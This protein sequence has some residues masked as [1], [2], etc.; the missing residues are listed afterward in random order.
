[1]L[2]LLQAKWLLGRPERWGYPELD[3]LGAGRLQ[4]HRIF[5][6][7]SPDFLRASGTAARGAYS[8]H[9]GRGSGR[10]RP[11]RKIWPRR[12]DS[13]LQRLMGRTWHAPIAS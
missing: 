6:R 9:E 13:A 4:T 11:A 2:R 8:S 10:S 3:R 12:F 7:S 5:L 1:M